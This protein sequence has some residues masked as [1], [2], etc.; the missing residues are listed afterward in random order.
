M[1][2]RQFMEQ[3]LLR[4]YGVKVLLIGY[5]N[6]FG[7]NRVEGFDDYVRYGKELGIEVKCP[8]P[9]LSLERKG[10]CLAVHSSV[11]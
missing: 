4:Q 6:R 2:A 8:Q 9:L 5:D 10:S 3:V 7:H 1:T 11:N